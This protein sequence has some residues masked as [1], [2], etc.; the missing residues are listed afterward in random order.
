MVCM[1]YLCQCPNSAADSDYAITAIDKQRDSAALIHPSAYFYVK[2]LS[3]IRIF[4]EIACRDYSNIHAISAL[5]AFHRVFHDP[6]ATAAEENVAFL[7]NLPSDFFC[8]IIRPFRKPFSPRTHDS[9][10]Q[11]VL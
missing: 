5:A 2:M 10:L 6:C 8:E 3:K 4:P 9:N 7:R 1:T 11:S